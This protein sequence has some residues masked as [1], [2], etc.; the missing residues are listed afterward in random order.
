MNPNAPLTVAQNIAITSA[1]TS[2]LSCI[3]ATY[4]GLPIGPLALGTAVNSGIAGATFFSLREYIVSPILLTTI[5]SGQFLR[6]KQEVDAIREGRAYTA[7]RLD[8][9]SMRSHKLPDT[10]L[11]G[12]LTGG[13]LNAWKGGRSGIAPGVTTGG[14]LCTLLQLA[15]N[16]LGVVRLKYLSRTLQTQEVAP[17][18]SATKVA[19][20]SSSSVSV[21]TEPVPWTE[22]IFSLFGLQKVSDEEY[23]A[24]LKRDRDAH[25]R[26]IA[27]LERQFQ[28]PES[29]NLDSSNAQ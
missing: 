24:R 9:W 20:T 28:E 17:S 18:V 22:R 21:N 3:Y 19:T 14:L 23:L 25:L 26:R 1:S 11:S 8:W 16:E 7:E 29:N 4:K 5:S 10:A 2:F 27:E 15:Y 6:R 12:A 13:L